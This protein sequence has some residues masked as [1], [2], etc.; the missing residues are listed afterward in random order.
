MMNWGCSSYQWDS[1]DGSLHFQGRTFDTMPMNSLVLQYMPRGYEYARL[2]ADPSAGTNKLKY[3]FVGIGPAVTEIPLFADGVNEKGLMGCMLLFPGYASYTPMD[4]AGPDGLDPAFFLG[5]ALGMCASTPEV[6][7]FAKRTELVNELVMGSVATVHFIFSDTTGKTVIIE[8]TAQTLKIYEENVGV[9]TNAPDYPWMMT[10]LKNYVGIRQISAM[11]AEID[12]LKFSRFGDGDGFLG[13]PSDY[14]PPA[15]FVR[16]AM[17]R[18][19]LL[20]GRNEPDCVNRMFNGFST[21]TIPEGV[22][23][24]DAGSFNVSGGTE[25]AHYDVS[26]YTAVMCAESRTYYYHT[27]NTRNVTAIRLDPLLGTAEYKKW[28]VEQTPKYDFMN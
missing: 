8:P 4:K 27:Y 18:N 2:L 17:T 13:L 7:D 26:L 19:W 1:A 14:S 6:I 20:K 12:G 5:T 24:T 10:N 21:V 15:R 28:P 23:K 16:L 11:P 9:M 25:T 22:V 3:G